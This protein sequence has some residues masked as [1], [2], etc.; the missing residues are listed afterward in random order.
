M[1]WGLYSSSCVREVLGAARDFGMYSALGAVQASGLGTYASPGLPSEVV[2][3]LSLSSLV[4]GGCWELPA[5][6]SWHDFPDVLDE[7][8]LFGCSLLWD[9][10]AFV[11]SSNKIWMTKRSDVLYLGLVTKSFP[12]LGVMTQTFLSRLGVRKTSPY[13]DMTR[14]TPPGMIDNRVSSFSGVGVEQLFLFEDEDGELSLGVDDDGD[15]VRAL[16]CS[17][18]RD[19]TFSLSEPADGDLSLLVDGDEDLPLPCDDDAVLVFSDDDVFSDG[20]PCDDFFFE[21]LLLFDSLD[22]ESDLSFFGVL[23]FCPFSDF[24]AFVVF[25]CLTSAA[26]GFASLADLRS[27]FFFFLAVFAILSSPKI[28]DIILS[29]P[30]ETE[31][32]SFTTITLGDFDWLVLLPGD[33]NFLSDC[34]DAVDLP[35][36]S[37]PLVSELLSGV[38]LLLS[39]GL[40]A[41]A[42]PESG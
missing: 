35:G 10:V 8:A 27:F 31:T 5:F 13:L 23:S 37:F 21:P 14:G 42:S 33:A 39:L 28:F 41:C 15:A 24:S 16:V 18:E 25:S 9:E 12:S 17:E 6:L 11:Q 29:N 1:G 36:V 20:F 19:E 7:V 4:S 26:T 22:D 38:A 2:V 3:F 40:G 30:E 32:V 34:G